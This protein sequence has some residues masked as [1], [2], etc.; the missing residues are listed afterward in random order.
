[1]GSNKKIKKFSKKNILLI[2]LIF[3]ILFGIIF[4]IFFVIPKF[5][6]KEYSDEITIEY[7]HK[8]K[9]N[10]GKICYGNIFDCYNVKVKTIGKVNTSKLGQYKIVYNISYKNKK[11][12]LNQKVLVVDK[13]NPKITVENKDYSI[14]PN[15]KIS[16]MKVSAF[17]NYDGDISK[18]IKTKVIDGKIVIEVKDSSNNKKVLK[19]DAKKEDKIP[20]TIN[21]NGSSTKT[22]FVGDNYEDEGA[23]AT[24]N[25]DENI[26][27]ETINEVNTSNEGTYKVIYKA[28]DSNS[29][30]STTERTIYVKN[31]SNGSRVVYLTFDDGPSS[32]T[33]KLLDTLKKY[34]VKA[35]F[36]VTGNGDDSIILREY[37]EGH[38]IALHTNTHNYSYLYSSVD[39]YF[40]DLYT[41][42]NRVKNITGYTSNLIRF[43]GG[44][45]NTVSMEY[46]GGI[47]IMSILTNEV[48]SRGFHYFDWNV[49]SGDAGG[50]DT[51]DGVFWN[52]VSNLKEGSSVVLQHDTQEFS[53]DAV[54]RIISYGLENGY[55]F[56]A[57]D[58]SSPTMHHGVNN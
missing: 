23:T 43:P 44:S 35:T 11:Y 49:S 8:Y 50:T 25:C 2:T 17:D 36:F 3:M 34:N 28:K 45:S 18:N 27:V 30:E 58:E 40:E 42:Q 16:N 22:I 38:R 57:L 5:R 7:K 26:N 51:S 14:C 39:N 10:Y 12:K 24:D 9:H 21:I 41:V 20:P 32:H 19:L 55:T 13:T 15:G 29:N 52:V 33:P 56:S 47:G 37:N 53:V 4:S 31:K 54:E 1:M 48:E 46:D 6:I